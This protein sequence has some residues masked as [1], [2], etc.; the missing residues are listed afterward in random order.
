LCI[1]F[2]CMPRNQPK[3]IQGSSVHHL[4]SANHLFTIK[5]DFSK[6]TGIAID[7]ENRL[8]IADSGRSVIYVLDRDGRLLESI[9]SFGWREGEFDS[10]ADVAVD[11]QFRLYIADSGNNRLQRFSLLNR[12]FSVIAGEKTH[13]VAESL[14][15]YGPQGVATDSRGYIYIVDTWK[16][17]I[18]KIDPLGRFQMEI[19]GLGQFRK[20]QSVVVDASGNIY[21]CDT[22]N[23]RICKFDFSG[24]QIAIWGEEGSRTGQFQNPTG[25]SRDRFGNIYIVDQGNHRI[26]V[27]NPDGLYLTEFG[28][29][30]LDNPTDVAIDNYIHVYV[31]DTSAGDIEVFKVSS[32]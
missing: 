14:S 22:G 18:L 30:N 26:Q 31:T 9:G 8:Y 27:F 7:F 19:G 20:P 4:K 2:C 12:D 15:L 21:A 10:P 23:N 5:G 13:E 28:Q 3:F 25:I 17:R 29:Q 32:E 1:V 11:V 16:D 6:P 24:S